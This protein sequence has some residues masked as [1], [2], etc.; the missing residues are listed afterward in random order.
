MSAVTEKSGRIWTEADLQAL[1][2]GGYNHEIVNGELV[3]SPKNNFQ[4]EQICQRLNF[5]LESFNRAH[6]LGSV[7]GSNMGFWMENRNCRAPDVSFV[8]KDRLLRQG[9]K[10]DTKTFFNGAPDLAVEVLSPNNT[11]GEMD[12]RLADFFASGAQ[13]VWVVHPDEQFVEACRTR[14]D[15]QIVGP[16]GFLEGDGIL[17]GFRFPV[18]DLFKQFDW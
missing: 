16:A 11:R 12:A 7:F 9:F 5:A 2:D 13:I 17:P 18:G 15:R 1:P 4:H 6:R 3:M 14:V 10:P 8:A